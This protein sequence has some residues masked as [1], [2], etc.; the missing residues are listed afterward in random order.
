MGI[1]QTVCAGSVIGQRVEPITI[2]TDDVSC[3]TCQIVMK[4][5][6]VLGDKDG[7]GAFFGL[8]I[9]FQRD[10]QGRFYVVQQ[11]DDQAPMIFGSDGR[12]LERLGRAGDGPGETRFARQIIVTKHDSL[13]VFD[14][15]QDGA[16][17]SR[18]H[19]QY[20]QSP[21]AYGV[22]ICGQSPR[23][24][25]TRLAGLTFHAASS[26][27]SHNADPTAREKQPVPFVLHTAH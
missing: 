17:R 11:W 1:L 6:V 15:S 5:V 21:Q 22:S 23:R 19:D 16:P 25:R 24:G 27:V 9:S 13:I 10:S 3:P 8:P 12:F 18:Q 20:A 2:G 26:N 4:Q 7:P 14:Q